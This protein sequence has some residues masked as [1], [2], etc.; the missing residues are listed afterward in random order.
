MKPP[1][2]LRSASGAGLLEVVVAATLTMLVLGAVVQ[3]TDRGLG[4]FRQGSANNEIEVRAARAMSRLV[5]ELLGSSSGI[6][7]PNLTTPP[8]AATV[9]SSVLDYRIGES[10]ADGAVVW[11][12]PR[13]LAWELAPGETD[14]DLDDD[15]DGLA[16]Q[17]ALVLVLDAGAPEEQR[18]VLVNGVREWFEGESANGLDDNGNGLV[19]E[20]GLAFALAG[21]VLTIRLSLERRG[22]DGRTIVRSQQTSIRLRNSGS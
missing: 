6:V 15:G 12:E 13:R 3:S 9:W 14:N 8:G 19:D 16:D 10:Y 5:R 18:V 22:P 20:R 7:Q 1:P 21:D 17:G 4:A 2:A 11:S